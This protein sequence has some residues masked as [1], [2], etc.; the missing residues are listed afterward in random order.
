MFA[1]GV[2]VEGAPLGFGWLSE[3]KLRKTLARACRLRQRLTVEMTSIYANRLP[4]S[5][6][7]AVR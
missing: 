6:E 7:T 2:L 5:A 3:H 1:P 4:C